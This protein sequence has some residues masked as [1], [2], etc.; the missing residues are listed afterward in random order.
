MK[1]YIV[2]AY[3]L[4][5]AACSSRLREE[6]QWASPKQRKIYSQYI[7]LRKDSYLEYEEQINNKK[8]TQ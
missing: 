1:Q 6:Y 8:T 7:Y 3:I 2:I 5:K 4:V